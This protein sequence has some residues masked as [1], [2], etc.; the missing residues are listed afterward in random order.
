[1]RHLFNKS[2]L[3]VLFVLYAPHL[4]AGQPINVILDIDSNE[5]IAPVNKLILGNNVISNK[6]GRNSKFFKSTGGG[7][8]NPVKRRTVR[9]A[10]ELIQQAGVTA[11]R[12]PGGGWPGSMNFYSLVGEPDKRPDNKF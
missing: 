6:E 11:L 10:S 5:V 3:I 8:W 1:M 2:G 4:L 9:D 12:W 7:L